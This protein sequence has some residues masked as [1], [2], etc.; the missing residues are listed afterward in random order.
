MEE[1]L[2]MRVIVLELKIRKI[3][4]QENHVSCDS[5]A[6]SQAQMKEIERFCSY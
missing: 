5:M 6:E 4:S 1:I 2:L 3:Q